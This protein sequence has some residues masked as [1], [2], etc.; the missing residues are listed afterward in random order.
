MLVVS[1][2]GKDDHQMSAD[3]PKPP[4]VSNPVAAS[5]ETLVA[6]KKLKSL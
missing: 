1:G 4:S 2:V 5:D 6:L 3:P